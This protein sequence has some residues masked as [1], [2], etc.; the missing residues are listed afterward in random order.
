M[1]TFEVVERISIYE[2]KRTPFDTLEDAVVLMDKI[3]KAGGK[4]YVYSYEDGKPKLEAS[5]SDNDMNIAHHDQGDF[6]D[7]SGLVEHSTMERAY[8][9]R[10]RL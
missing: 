7:H 2:M 6:H 1:R 3:H 9:K 4:S 10:G 8:N 5:G